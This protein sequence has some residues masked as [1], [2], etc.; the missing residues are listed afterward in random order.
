MP[1]LISFLAQNSSGSACQTAVA[2][3]VVQGELTVAVGT[4]A[5]LLNLVPAL[6][7]GA[8]AGFGGQIVNKGCYDLLATITYLTG[9]DCDSCTTPDT[10]TPVVITVEIPKNSAF[11]IP[12]G[13][14]TTVRIQTIDAAN[15]P[16]NVTTEQS[17]YFYSAYKPSCPTC[18]ILVP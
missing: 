14:F 15:A 1:Q 9:D 18:V 13:F 17:V 3:V 12:D 2:P 16:I 8:K 5:A 6:A 11:P 7:T 4:G 10:L